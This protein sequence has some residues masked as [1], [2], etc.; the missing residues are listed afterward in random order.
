[1]KKIVDL[2]SNI[3]KYT[4]KILL[5]DKTT[6]SNIIWATDT[7]EHLGA[8]YSS[9]APIT[10][11]IISGVYS[12]IIQPR[13]YKSQTA[14]AERTRKRAEVFTPTWLCNKMNNLIDTQWFGREN[15]FNTP[16]ADGKAWTETKE[17]I[18]F[19]Q[20]K[21]W[22]QYVDT[23][24]LEITCGEAP[25]LVSRYD[26]TTGEIIPI[27]HRIGILDRKLRVVNENAPDEKWLNWVMRAFESTYGFEYQG[28][29]LLVA[30]INLL[31]TFVDYY[32]HKWQIM[33]DISIT[34]KIANRIAWN[35]W[36][37]D[38]LKGTVPQFKN[39]NENQSQISMFSRETPD[40]LLYND[41]ECLIY[42]WRQGHS[43]TYNSLRREK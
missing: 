40:Q 26:T 28:D 30:R 23:R 37:M 20:G 16:T 22:Q 3:F 43:Q 21:T 42:D 35:I 13:V 7:Y 4:A 6:K 11:G 32:M 2:E 12:D 29:N 24:R 27:E 18:T 19:P 17:K 9:D 34:K 39:E 1:M 33:P 8:A 31:M 5:Q 38:G 10:S 14:Q 15:V 25:Y 36:Q 41:I